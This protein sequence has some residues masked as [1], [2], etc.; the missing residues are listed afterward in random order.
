MEYWYQR[1]QADQQRQA[2][3]RA[4]GRRMS[5]WFWDLLVVLVIEA[6]LVEAKQEGG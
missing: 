5:F 1:I 3:I 2:R 4:G 6:E